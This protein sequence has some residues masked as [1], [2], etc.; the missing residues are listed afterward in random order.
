LPTAQ[1]SVSAVNEWG[2]GAQI[3][4]DIGE[5]HAQVSLRELVS[6]AP[7]H[8]EVTWY[9]L[10]WDMHR[11]H[12][13]FVKVNLEAGRIS[14]LAKEQLEFQDILIRSPQDNQSVIC[15]LDHRAW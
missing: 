6:S 4:F 9:I 15:I 1:V 10:L 12:C 8:G 5:R 3:E 11:Y 7:Q 13:A 14:E 2:K